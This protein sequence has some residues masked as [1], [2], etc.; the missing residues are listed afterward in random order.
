MVSCKRD[1]ESHPEAAMAARN[2]PES[3]GFPQSILL[4]PF[5]NGPAKQ[6]ASV[7]EQAQCLEPAQVEAPAPNTDLEYE[8]FE[9]SSFG[10][11]D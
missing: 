6:Q 1:Y 10:Q 4:N 7:S 9:G 5:L 3:S 8:Y 11:P 2:K